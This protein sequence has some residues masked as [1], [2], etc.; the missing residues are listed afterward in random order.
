ME[1]LKYVQIWIDNTRAYLDM[2]EKRGEK[3]SPEWKRE[4]A[5]LVKWADI[6]IELLR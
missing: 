2:L 3:G 4:V 5:I 6:Q 1:D